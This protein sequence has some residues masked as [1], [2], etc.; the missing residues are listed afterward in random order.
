MDLGFRGLGFRVPCGGAGCLSGSC[1]GTWLGFCVVG[2]SPYGFGEL[3]PGVCRV[4]M[5]ILGLRYSPP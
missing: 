3:R 1:L 5:P 4:C 2:S